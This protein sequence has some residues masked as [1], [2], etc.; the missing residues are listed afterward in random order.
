MEIFYFTGDHKAR[1]NQTRLVKVLAF[2]VAAILLSCACFAQ[3]EK[4]FGSSLERTELIDLRFESTSIRDV[5]KTL[6][7]L[8]QLNVL[9]TEDVKG[10]VTVSLHQVDWQQALHL[11]LELQGL[12]YSLYDNIMLVA[13]A[14]QI[15]QRQLNKLEAK[16][17]IEQKRAL[18]SMTISINYAKAR[19]IAETLKASDNSIMTERGQVTVDERTN[20]LIIRDTQQAL[21][22]IRNVINHLD[23]PARQVLI[24][25]RMVTVRDNIDEQLG[26][27]WGLLSHS[28]DSKN[29]L[30]SSSEQAAAI[31]SAS[32]VNLS[33]ADKFNVNLPVTNP[34]GRF[35]LQMAKLADGTLLDLELSALERE[36]KGE[37]VATPRV[38]ATNQNTSRIEQGTEI[39]YLQ[40]A[41]HGATS[42]A[43]KRAVLSLEVTPQITPNNDIILELNITQDA[44]GESVI[45]STG[46][47]VAIDTQQI[48]TKVSV[49]NGETIVLGGIYQQQLINAVTKVPLLGDIPYLGQLFRTE[50]SYNEK[51]EL[52]VFVTPKI[53]P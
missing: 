43:F 13:P 30:A 33:F 39:P 28:S 10:Q 22:D 31:S 1:C 48:K 27:R 19:D 24:E 42:V 37:I 3:E 9:M 41:A 17:K 25:A 29:I 50:T 35:A 14:Q 15:A 18:V 11:V 36:S 5:L 53:A 8:K 16:Y 12:S 47:A 4:T 38:L 26:V 23:A 32:P 34:A 46:P 2:V 40:A 51:R 20:S 44:R 7:Q 49:K 21:V 6:A 52:L 45:T